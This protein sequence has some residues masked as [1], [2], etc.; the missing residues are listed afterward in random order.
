MTAAP[1]AP[2]V[3]HVKYA[4]NTKKVCCIKKKREA[5][6]APPAS[7]VENKLKN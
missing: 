2:A 4:K 7:P 3:S 1:M 5:A 6:P